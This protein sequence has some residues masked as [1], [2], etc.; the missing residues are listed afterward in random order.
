MDEDWMIEYKK[1]EMKNGSC[2]WCR[3]QK[4]L[5]Y[6]C[7]CKEV[8][9]CTELCKE[10]DVRFHEDRCKK[11]FEIEEVSIKKTDK[12][13]LGLVGLC[14]LGNTC[15]MNTALQCISNCFELTSF[16]LEGHYKTQLNVDNPIGSQGVLAKSYANLLSNLWYGTNDVFSPTKFKRAIECFQSMVNS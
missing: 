5:R 10:R 7:V 8:W 12:S 13:R 6:S 3:N 2:E 9:Y 4:M 1:I 16:F 15:F 14:N 11:R